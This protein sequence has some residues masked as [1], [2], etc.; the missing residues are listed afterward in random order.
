MIATYYASPLVQRQLVMHQRAR[1]GSVFLVAYDGNRMDCRVDICLPILK[2]SMQLRVLRSTIL[3]VPDEALQQC[4][5]VRHIIQV[6][7]SGETILV[8]LIR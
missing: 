6:C 7:R 8:Q 5:M 3:K 2:K 4:R 1:L